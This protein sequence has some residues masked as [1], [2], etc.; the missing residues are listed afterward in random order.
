MIA[1][2]RLFTP[3]AERLLR[4]SG[5]PE[6]WSLVWPAGLLGAAMALLVTFLVAWLLVNVISKGL[7][8]LTASTATDLDDKILD[9]LDK[10]LRRL[11]VA[12][13]LYMASRE[14]P[15]SRGTEMIIGG[16]L[17]I[18]IVWI[19]VKLATRVGLVLLLAYGSRVDDE[20]GKERFEKDYVPLL[21]KALGTVLAIVG[22]IAVLHH[23]GQNVSSLVAALGIGGVAISLAAKET[24]GNMFAGFIILVDRPFRPGD[25]I[26]LASGE[27]GDVVDVGTRS[28]RVKLFDQNMLIVPNNELVNSRVVNFN[29]PT[30]ATR[31]TLEL[32]V[33]YGTDVALAKKLILEIVTAQPEVVAVPAP[34][35]ILNGFGDSALNLFAWYIISQFADAGAVQDRVRVKVYEK[36]NETGIKIPY[37]TRELI[38]TRDA[39]IG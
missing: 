35:V 24:L 18:Y 8:R 1:P 33:A 21:S 5:Y 2:V 13:G 3:L 11:I 15:V 34:G 36:F 30:H 27:S 12:V 31:A 7:R 6:E 28:T 17:V 32:G 9:I 37:P 39:P 14:L 29:Y 4:T 20:I 22:L 16:A 26:K 10:P 23:F 25:R 38:V 19:G